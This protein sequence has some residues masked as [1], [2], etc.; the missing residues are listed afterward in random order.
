[1]GLANWL[2]LLVFAAKYCCSVFLQKTGSLGKFCCLLVL[3]WVRY[4]GVIVKEV[5]YE[6][7]QTVDLNYVGEG[8][9]KCGKENRGWRWRQIKSIAR[10][11][12]R[13][14]TVLDVLMSGY[15]VKVATN[16]ANFLWFCT[17]LLHKN[18]SV[19]Q[20]KAQHQKRHVFYVG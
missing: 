20:F 2:Q 11:Q 3:D 6:Y 1:M 5:A 16:C 9:G 15:Q 12:L 13:V 7:E 18:S 8:N 10:W 17:V 14:S 4:R 19:L